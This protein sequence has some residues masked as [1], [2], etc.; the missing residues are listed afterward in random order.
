[1]VCSTYQIPTKPTKLL[2]FLENKVTLSV[3]KNWSGMSLVKSLD[4]WITFPIKIPKMNSSRFEELLFS[5]M[6]YMTN[7]L[8]NQKQEPWDYKLNKSTVT[9]SFSICLD[10]E[11][12]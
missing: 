8:K 7:Q 6:R 1:M 9:F 5:I 11:E 12:K 4:I 2:M 3:T 10:L